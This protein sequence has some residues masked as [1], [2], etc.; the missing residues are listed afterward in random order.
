MTDPTDTNMRAA[1]K[2]QSPAAE[3]FSMFLRNYAAVA[4]L[5]VLFFIVLASI[6]GPILYPTDPFDMV[7][8]LLPRLGRR[9]AHAY[10]RVFS[11]TANAFVFYGLGGSVWCIASDDYICHWYCKLDCSGTNYPR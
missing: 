7:W 11:G 4:A 1:G 9:S 3:A 2:A 8:A 6:F 10:Y 5:V